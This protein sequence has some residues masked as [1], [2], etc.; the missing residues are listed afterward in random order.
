MVFL[1]SLLQRYWLVSVMA[2]FEWM[3]L[4]RAIVLSLPILIDVKK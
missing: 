2:F 3:V 4:L 1:V